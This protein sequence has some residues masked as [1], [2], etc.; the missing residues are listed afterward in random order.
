MGGMLP[1]LHF[2]IVA[3]EIGRGV[4]RMENWA[5][6]GSLSMEADVVLGEDDIVVAL[7]NLEKR[8][9]SI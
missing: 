5:R 9:V 6:P 2:R 8:G 7:G 1:A 3:H 4:W